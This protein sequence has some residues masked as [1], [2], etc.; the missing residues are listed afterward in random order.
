MGFL[1][2]LLHKRDEKKEEFIESEETKHINNV[3]QAYKNTFPKTEI[4]NETK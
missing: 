1:S 4:D 3:I 2:K